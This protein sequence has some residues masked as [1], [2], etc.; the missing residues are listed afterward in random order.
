M[1]ESNRSAQAKRELAQLH[2]K[3]IEKVSVQEAKNALDARLLRH[4]AE[5]EAARRV[6]YDK[7]VP[8]KQSE[9][10]RKKR[11]RPGQRPKAQPVAERAAG[12]TGRR[13]GQLIA[14]FKD[15]DRDSEKSDREPSLLER[16]AQ[17][18]K[19]VSEEPLPR[20]EGPIR[21]I[22]RFVKEVRYHRARMKPRTYYTSEKK[23]AVYRAIFADSF[24]PLANAWEDL[25]ETSWNF[26]SEIGR[27]AWALTLF[28]VDLLVKLAFYAW[29][30][31][32]SLWDFFWDL[33]YWIEANKL[34]FLR[35]F[36]LFVFSVAVIAIFI[37]T[38]TAYEY[39]Y[40]GKVLGT[41]K[42]Q[43]EVYKTIEVL[44]DKLS[45]ASGANV[46]LNVERDI[47][48]RRVMGF[49]LDIDTDEDILNTLTYMKDIHVVA[50][51]IYI[52]DKPRVVLESEEVAHSLLKSIRDTYAGPRPGV[53]Y[54]SVSFRE[55]ITVREEGV[56]LGEIWNQKDA[57]RYLMSGMKV[58]RKHIVAQDETIAQIAKKYDMEQADL[59]LAN[60]DIN[61]GRLYIGQELYLTHGVPLVTVHSTETA[62]YSEEIDY[63]T[64]YIDNASIYQ[65]E[66]EV[67]SRGIPG[68][69][70]I[71]AEIVR[72][73][74][75]EV[76]TKILSSDRVSEPVDEVQYRGTKPVPP[77]EG[78]GTFQYPIRTYT[79]SSRF[80]MRWGRMHTGVDFAAPSGTKIYAADG[81][82]VTFSGWKGQLGYTVI[83]NHGSLFE[84]YY[85][86]CSKLLVSAGEKVYQGQNIALVGS[87]G[88][89]T[90]SHL[91]F[92]VRYHDRPQNPLDYL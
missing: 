2:E 81:G 28:C 1:N 10:K 73:N 74:G 32:L 91:H 17:R 53:E 80:G 7:K 58:E 65:G 24:A 14:S 54:S 69:Q 42:N 52:D 37:G 50:Y 36:V 39:S 45:E 49:R 18:E 38:I 55:N 20:R 31:V 62:T 13:I 23:R 34:L 92:E 56:K 64:Q 43:Y 40:Y 11:K 76:S 79:I 5:R 77:K 19:S 3:S 33:R 41:A 21:R 59:E 22:R 83:I 16:F 15:R 67:K 71:V 6:F 86:H 51:I 61:L 27:D 57:K 48:F 60:P 88:Y 12:E 85:G 25:L 8:R 47:E 63:D 87:T 89:S 78:T 46:S 90:G 82:V 29:G 35:R 4:Q 30:G 84:T 26:F 9:G 68:Q 44:G 70:R 75:E 72:T 66:T